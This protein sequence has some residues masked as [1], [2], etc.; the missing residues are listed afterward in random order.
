M[1][2][3]SLCVP[4]CLKLLGCQESEVGRSGWNSH[5]GLVVGHGKLHEGP[6]QAVLKLS[7]QGDVFA[8]GLKQDVVSSHSGMDAA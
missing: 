8:S 5:S 1:L 3:R 4:W 2:S 7:A 6:I